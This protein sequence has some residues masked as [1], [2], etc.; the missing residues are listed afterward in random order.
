MPFSIQSDDHSAIGLM[1]PVHRSSSNMDTTALGLMEGGEGVSQEM[2]EDTDTVGDMERSSSMPPPPFP[3][4]DQ[5]RNRAQAGVCIQRQQ[6]IRRHS[7]DPAHDSYPTR[8]NAIRGGRAG[9]RAMSMDEGTHH[10]TTVTS[11]SGNVG[12]ERGGA[13][14]TAA[15]GGVSSGASNQPSAGGMGQLTITEEDPVIEKVKTKLVED[16]HVALAEVVDRMPA[17]LHDAIL[18]ETLEPQCM[19]TLLIR[20][21][22]L[23]RG[24]LATGDAD[25]APG[26]I[27][28]F[29]G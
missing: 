10:R 29:E 19:E 25:S 17:G 11:G 2:G 16:D 14:A 15:E 3:P 18:Q 26:T 22:E 28:W 13:S 21:A 9:H 27:H 12:G 1:S 20:V 4:D 23:K 6:N 7:H 5:R 8:R 24:R